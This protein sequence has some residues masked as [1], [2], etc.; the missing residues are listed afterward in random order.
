MLRR[1]SKCWK[2]ES[3]ERNAADHQDFTDTTIID[4]R[5][6]APLLPAINKSG[7]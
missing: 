7:W 3:R 4:P 6:V 2:K 1:R 5:F